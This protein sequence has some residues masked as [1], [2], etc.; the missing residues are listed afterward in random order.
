MH[1]NYR[2]DTVYYIYDFK[3]GK[4]SRIGDQYKF[5]KGYLAPHFRLKNSASPSKRSSYIYTEKIVTNPND[6]HRKEE[7][8]YYRSGSSTYVNIRVTYEKV[9]GCYMDGYGRIINP[10]D[11]IDEVIAYK[12]STPKKNKKHYSWLYNYR[13]GMRTRQWTKSF[14][15]YRI[16]SY[17][18]SLIHHSMIDESMLRSDEEIKDICRAYH[19]RLR[20]HYSIDWDGD[21]SKQGFGWKY[22]YKSNKQYNKFSGSKN[23][24]SI[25]T[26]DAYEEEFTSDEIDEML[27]EDF[28]NNI[29]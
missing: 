22:S 7:K 16:K 4:K 10:W 18:T 11:L 13:E 20:Q 14:S 1:Y 29:A 8:V 21:V 17:R 25:R 5:V 24:N 27:E 2:P 6:M 19:I 12:L 28:L 23:S 9:K 3:T 26:M 15:G